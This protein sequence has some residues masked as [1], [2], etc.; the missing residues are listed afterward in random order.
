MMYWHQNK[1]NKVN[2][3]RQEEEHSPDYSF[4]PN[5]TKKS[6]EIVARN[7]YAVGDVAF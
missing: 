1:E 7:N 4:H 2:E 3:L 6:L 5:I